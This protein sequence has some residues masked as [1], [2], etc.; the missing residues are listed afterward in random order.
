M[1]E[2]KDEYFTGIASIDEEHKK[3]F[4]IAEEAYNLSQNEFIPDKYDNVRDI[5]IQLRDYTRMHFEHEEAY[6]ESISYKR[7]F[8]QKVQHDAFCKKLDE[9][10]LAN[11]D[12]N[13]DKLILE[14]LDFLT[15]WLVSH[16]MENDKL[17]AEA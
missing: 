7:M 2:M 11:I 12:E 8:T 10:D 5:L 16:I 17:I 9:I 13:S 1:Y 14:I 4:S 3:L 15:D 6:M